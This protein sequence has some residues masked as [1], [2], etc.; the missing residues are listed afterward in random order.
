MKATEQYFLLTFREQADF[1]LC[2][3]DLADFLL[4]AKDKDED[5]KWNS[6]LILLPFSKAR[7]RLT[8]VPVGALQTLTNL[9]MRWSRRK[10]SKV[11]RR[12]R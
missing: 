10:S 3:G 5:K 12:G 4:V 8:T 1:Q 9:R 2:D 11:I 7:R 6:E